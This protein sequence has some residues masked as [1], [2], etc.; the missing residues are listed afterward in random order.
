MP[1]TPA[2][3]AVGTSGSCEMRSAHGHRE[4]AQLPA[5]DELQRRGNRLAHR[6]HL[7]A[8]EV[9]HRRAAALVGDVDHVGAD[10][11]PEELGAHALR[12]ARARRGVGELA[13]I[14]LRVGD[15]FLQ[16]SSPAATDVTT[17]TSGTEPTTATGTR[18]LPRS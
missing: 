3:A 10:L 2:S 6:E 13:G 9:A 5:L 15:E 14:G 18:S 17:Q 12:G 4:R 8:D 1:V 16:R 11:Q 7:A